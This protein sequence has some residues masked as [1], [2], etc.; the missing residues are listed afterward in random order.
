MIARAAEGSARDGLSILDQ[1]IAHGAGAVTAARCATCS[2][3]PIADAIRR[4]LELVLTGDAPRA[5]AALDE[6]HDLGIDPTQLLRGLME[7]LHSA[8]RAKAGASGGSL[9]SRRGARS[10][11]ESMARQLGMGNDP[12]LVAD[13]AQGPPGRRHCARP[14]RSCRNGAVAA[15]PCRGSARSRGP[16]R[17]AERRAVA[18]I[19]HRR[20]PAR[21]DPARNS[22]PISGAWS[23]LLRQQEA[24]PRAAAA[25]SRRPRPL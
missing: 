2:G 9:Q 11:A 24:A 16:A 4:L 19:V 8:T 10:A 17:K 5:L 20:R 6:A 22:A 23:R 13:A 1:A 3:L 15:H 14:A 21:T 25:R 18:A 12:P 7:S